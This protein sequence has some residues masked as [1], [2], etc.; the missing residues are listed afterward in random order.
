LKATSTLNNGIV[1]RRED[2][3]LSVFLTLVLSASR[4]KFSVI[5][6][7][8]QIPIHGSDSERYNPGRDLLLVLRRV[9]PDPSPI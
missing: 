4:D 1:S 2:A 8:E 9:Y 5:S 7:D 3:S 6:N